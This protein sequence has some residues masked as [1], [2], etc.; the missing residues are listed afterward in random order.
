MKHWGMTTVAAK[1]KMEW[2]PRLQDVAAEM[3]RLGIGDHASLC[4]Q[5]QQNKMARSLLWLA[6]AAA[7]REA[8]DNGYEFL[9]EGTG[10]E[11]Y[12]ELLLHLCLELAIQ[13][14]PQK[15]TSPLLEAILAGAVDYLR[16]SLE[17]A[18]FKLQHEAN[19][20]INTVGKDNIFFSLFNPN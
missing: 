7:I 5:A 17:K 12:P 4:Q 11:H 2:L 1:P 6:T 15:S 3:V 16:H 18:F 19:V 20:P 9:H 14:E 8:G 13:D 10:H